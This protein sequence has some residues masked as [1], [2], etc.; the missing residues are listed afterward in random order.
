MADNQEHSVSSEYS[1]K[2]ELV[3]AEPRCENRR[4]A[5]DMLENLACAAEGCLVKL[6][7]IAHLTQV[8]AYDD[9]LAEDGVWRL[10]PVRPAWSF[11]RTAGL[12]VEYAAEKLLGAHQLINLFQD[13]DVPSAGTTRRVSIQPERGAT[14]QNTDQPAPNGDGSKR[15]S[16][17]S[18]F[19]V[20]KRTSAGL[21]GLL[22]SAS[23]KAAEDLCLDD[24]RQ[25]IESARNTLRNIKREIHA[26]KSLNR[27]DCALTEMQVHRICSAMYNKIGADDETVDTATIKVGSV[28]GMLM[29]W[30]LTSQIQGA[31]RI[32]LTL[33]T[34]QGS[35]FFNS[36]WTVLFCDQHVG[37][38]GRNASEKTRFFP[39][40]K[41]KVGSGPRRTRTSYFPNLP[42]AAV[43]L[44]SAAARM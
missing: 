28:E 17:S 23:K 7:P 41:Q 22:S 4:N 1:E 16:T 15:G 24:K 6:G 13:S 8:F 27:L 10:M 11:S 38:L 3:E 9:F 18:A 44:P 39:L 32:P 34:F 20:H 30:D 19:P 36:A 21:A 31:W 37:A 26:M 25:A 5:T 42:W 33:T 29:G 40:K 35:D 14:D 12:A 2:A 43:A